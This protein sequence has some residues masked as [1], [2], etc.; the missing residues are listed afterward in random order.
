MTFLFRR[1]SRER[2]DTRVDTSVAKTRFRVTGDVD[3]DAGNR[4]MRKLR[5]QDTR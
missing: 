3:I 5:T 1:R 4:L 2:P